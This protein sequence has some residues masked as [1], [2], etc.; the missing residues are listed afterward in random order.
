MET[1]T[2][3]QGVI[4][5]DDTGSMSSARNEVRRRIKDLSKEL[6]NTIPNLELGIII[7][8]DY[9]D[10][11]LIQLLPFSSSQSTIEAFVNRSSS[12]GGGDHKEAYAYVLNQIRLMN[13]TADSKFAI[14]IGD[15]PPHEKG[16]RSAGHT[17]LYDWR[18]ES[19]LLG[20]NGIPI[21]SIQALHNRSSAFFY[22]GMAQLSKG[23]K[24]DL[25]Q[26][27]HITDYLLAI[28]HK[29][30][31]SLETFEDSK[32]EYKTNISFKG[33]FAK[34]KGKLDGKIESELLAKGELLSKF[35]VLD[36]Y[37][38][39]KIKKFVEDTGVKYRAG[40][41]F[42]ELVNSELIQAN[43]EVLFID[44]ETGETIMD[45]KWCREQMGLPFGT[46]GK[47]NPKNLEC[48][49]KYNIFVQS[50]SYTRDLDTGTKFLYELNHY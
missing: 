10:R 46:K 6:F 39:V 32:P 7:H 22:E 14:M 50:N 30:A 47:I 49:R 17:E 43:K 16:E 25:S 13:W 24:L 3:V 38:K 9:C 4:S 26:F 29:E 44:R 15:A 21:Y 18:E 23:I 31:G 37:G 48:N 8:N 41:G 36:V 34:L 28:A 11:D 45:T 35:Q 40:R 1:V 5:F 33:M 19:K 27:S 2:K 12:Q 42:Y 20:I